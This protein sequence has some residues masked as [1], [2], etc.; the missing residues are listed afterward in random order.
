MAITCTDEHSAIDAEQFKTRVEGLQLKNN[1]IPPFKHFGRYG[2][3][4]QPNHLICDVRKHGNLNT[5]YF[6]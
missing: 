4:W 5:V 1:K 2:T 3:H 6:I